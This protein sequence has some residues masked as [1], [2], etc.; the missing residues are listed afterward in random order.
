VETSL[1]RERVKKGQ[2]DCLFVRD[3]HCI[4][5]GDEVSP[6]FSIIIH[7]PRTGFLEHRQGDDGMSLRREYEYN[8]EMDWT[9]L[10]GRPLGGA[11]GVDTD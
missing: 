10:I 5:I 2:Q 9:T 4:L 1:I 8:Y 6:S 3:R 11:A 7:K